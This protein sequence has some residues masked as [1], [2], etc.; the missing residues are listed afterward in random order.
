MIEY[1][2]L[3]CKES[4]DAFHDL[5]QSGMMCNSAVLQYGVDSMKYSNSAITI[6]KVAAVRIHGDLASCRVDDLPAP[7]QQKNAQGWVI[8]KS[9]ST[10]SMSRCQE[11]H[12]KASRY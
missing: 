7:L 9:I 12:K 3:K 11:E 8:V 1:S 4:F 6:D 5:K 10:I 2:Q